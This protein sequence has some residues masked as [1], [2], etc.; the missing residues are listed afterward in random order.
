MSIFKKIK[1]MLENN[2]LNFNRINN[3]PLSVNL[4]NCLQLIK[5]EPQ[6]K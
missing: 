6:I 4:K 1:K 2:I 5:K 3:N